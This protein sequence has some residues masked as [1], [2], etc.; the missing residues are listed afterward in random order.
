[1]SKLVGQLKNHRYVWVDKSFTHRNGVGFIP[2]LWFGLVSYPGRLWGCT[3]LLESGAI[4][5]NLPAHAI[6]FSSNPQPIWK[7]IDAQTWDCYGFGFKVIEYKYLSNIQNLKAKTKRGNYYNGEYL[8]TVAPVGDSFSA[9]PEQAKEF[10]FCRLDNDRLTIQ[11][12]NCLVFSDIS[13]T[14]NKTMEFPT[15]VD[16]QTETYSCE[17]LRAAKGDK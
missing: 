3:V 15:D 9:Y 5:R 6:A 17:G 14:T 12:T 16:R 2:A 10:C 11:P 7:E 13:F 4:Y 8:F 1:M